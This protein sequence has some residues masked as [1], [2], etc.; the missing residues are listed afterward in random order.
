M[1]NNAEERKSHQ[2][3]GGSLKSRILPSSSEI[4][5]LRHGQLQLTEGGEC[6]FHRSVPKYKPTRRQYPDNYHFI[7]RHYDAA[8]T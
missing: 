8:K 3:R 1:R 4:K 5:G 7:K 2:H 6:T